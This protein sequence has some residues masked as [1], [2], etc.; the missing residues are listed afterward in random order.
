MGEIEYN[1]YVLLAPSKDP[2]ARKMRLRRRRGDGDVD[3]DQARRVL[4]GMSDVAKD[5]GKLKLDEKVESVK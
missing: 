2:I 3:N 1:F 4:K 5:K